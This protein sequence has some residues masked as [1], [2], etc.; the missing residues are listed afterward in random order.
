MTT[1]I[2]NQDPAT[3]AASRRRLAAVFTVTSL[4]AFMS[5]LDLSIV[6][7]AFPA[8]ARSFPGDSRATLA[9]V[10]TGYAIVFG[11]LMVSGG[12]AADR[13]GRRPVFFAGIAMFC[14]GSALCAA[15]PAL[16]VLVAGRAVQAI[17]TALLV[18]SSLGL[19]LEEF[20]AGSRSLAVSLWS[21]V[22]GLAVATGP[23]LGAALIQAAG[24][25]A[26]FYVNL[27][28][29]LATWAWGRGVLPRRPPPAA[30][31][32]GT[33]YPG[34]LLSAVCLAGLVFGV[35]E[36]PGWGWGD[37][38]VVAAFLLAAVTGTAFVRR[39][40]G[41][42]A[43]VLDL[44]LFRHRSF[45]VAN[46][47][48]VL[49]AMAFFAMLLGN[50]L[51]L[52]GPLHYTVL[53]AGLAVTPAP[54]IVAAICGPAGHWAR[55]AGFRTVLACG[56]AVFAASFCWLIAEAGRHEA[57]LTG[58]LP[59]MVGCGIGIGLTYP[60]LGAAAVT[61]LP[62]SR[63]AVGSAVVQTA[64]QVG[65]AIGVAVLV[66]ILGSAGGGG[67]PPVE[68]FR[69]LWGC[70]AAMSAAALGLSLLLG[71]SDAGNSGT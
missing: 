17:G 64:R 53:R 32:A 18:P 41:H 30:D 1:V 34:V 13:F 36:G 27:P 43:P 60:V 70:C 20:P 19:L 22:G 68:A 37:G 58:W 23:S 42:A 61:A 15:A 40:H 57:Y 54:L 46:A 45:S 63:F 49:Y 62:P 56:F 31:V 16:P 9:W 12:R 65:G 38:W 67:N 8:L 29:G 39:C 50:I 10:I 24:W 33:D 44:R 71:P 47:A 4:G 14:L 52:T 26:A 35:S 48:M 3:G 2:T 6:N 51:F 11:A 28:V 69:V 59:G 21:G 55:S 7:V 66:A 25:R 5:S